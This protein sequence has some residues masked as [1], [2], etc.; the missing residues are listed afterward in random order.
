MKDELDLNLAF[1]SRHVAIM[2][3]VY[4]PEMILLSK[5]V[6]PDYHPAYVY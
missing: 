4:M 6:D 3:S 1:Q 2:C 5:A